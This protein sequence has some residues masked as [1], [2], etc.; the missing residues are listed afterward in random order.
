[1]S[2]RV[3]W[4]KALVAALT[5]A[6]LVAGCA[7]PRFDD[8]P[9]PLPPTEADRDA[10]LIGIDL[11]GD[12]ATAVPA[13]DYAPFDRDK[14][15]GRLAAARAATSPEARASA[16]RE[17]AT[18]WPDL[19]EAWRG[20]AEAAEA[21]GNAEEAEAARFVARRV[22]ALPGDNMATQREGVAALEIWLAEARADP[23][24]NPLTVAYADTLVSYWKVRAAARGT[25]EPPA[26]FLNARLID[27]PAVLLTGGIGT[28]YAV[29]LLGGSSTPE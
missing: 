27:L 19:L 24:A 2:I 11:D 18:A 13:P 10:P 28:A 20:L 4:G 21:A 1:M 29:T 26:R 7:L 6:W 17:A 3:P 16:F 23:D 5:A 8:A 14:G 12:E 15:L 22:D 25:Y 9:P